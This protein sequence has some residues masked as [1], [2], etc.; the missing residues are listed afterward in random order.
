MALGFTSPAAGAPL[1]IR[2]K[3]SGAGAGYAQQ[4]AVSSGGATTAFTGNVSAPYGN[5]SALSVIS[6]RRQLELAPGDHTHLYQ[7]YFYRRGYG[8]SDPDPIFDDY[9]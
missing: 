9:L 8:R 3:G 5:V 1:R 2:I 6:E 7:R 4:L